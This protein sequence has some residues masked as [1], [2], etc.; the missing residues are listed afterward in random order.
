MLI[1]DIAGALCSIGRVVRT[2]APAEGQGRA[3]AVGL[4]GTRL[5]FVARCWSSH[6]EAKVRLGV[7]QLAPRRPGSA[8]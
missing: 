1:R 6:R 2:S 8:R 3:R 7:D 4:S 5:R